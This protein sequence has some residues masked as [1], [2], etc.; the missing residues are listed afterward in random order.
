MAVSMI[1]PVALVLEQVAAPVAV[2]APWKARVQQVDSVSVRSAGRERLKAGRVERFAPG[3]VAWPA[4]QEAAVDLT[5]RARGER[6]RAGAT[7]VSLGRPGQGRKAPGQAR[8]RIVEREV[9]EQLVGPGIVTVVSAEPGTTTEVQLDYSSFAAAAGAGFGSRLSLVAL[10]ACALTTPELAECQ[11]QTDLGSVNDT[12]A[13]T[14]T[15]TVD[16]PATATE[17]PAGTPSPDPSA[18]PTEPATPSASPTAE[19]TPSSSPTPAPAGSQSPAARENLPGE[20]TPAAEPLAL[21]AVV[22]AAAAT[23]SS[24]QGDYTQTSLK[25][26]SSWT[27]GGSS[28]EFTW[29]YPL[30]VPSVPGGL[31]PELGIVYSSGGTDG[32]VSNTNNQASWV[33][34]GFELAGSFIERK[35]ANCYDDRSGGTNKTSN[36]VDLCWDTDSVKTNNEKWDNAFL[37]MD[38]HS[39]ELVREANTANW[40]LEKDDGTRIAK[41]GTAAANN[42]YWRVTT[43][44]GTQYF[45]GKGKA[46][47]SGAAATNSVWKVP[48]SGN[49]SG[50]PGYNSSFG[51]SFVSRPWRW[52]L[53]YVVSPTGN[54]A[55]YYW[56]KEAN[57]YKKNLATSTT[58]D[59]GG[60]LTKIQYGERKAAETVDDSPAKVTFTVEERCDTTVSSTCLTAAPTSSTAK[61]WPDVPMDAYCQTDYCPSQKTS[62]TFFSRKRL[63]Q[64]DTF[65]RNSAGDSW[66]TVDSWTLSGS[67]PAPADGGAVPSLWLASITHTGKAGTTITQPAVTL[68]PMMLDSRIAGSG[69]ALEKPRLALITAETGAQTIVEYS[70]PDCTAATLP[71]E[72]QAPTNTTR[73][74]PVYYSAG[75]AAPTLQWFNKYVVTSVTERDLTGYSDVNLEPLGLDISA[76]QVTSYTYVDGGAWRYNDSPLL[77]KKYRTWSNWRGYGKVVTVTGSGDTRGVVEDTFFRGMNGDR[78]SA[79]GGTRTAEVTDSTGTTWPDEDWFTGMTRET[80]TLTTVNGPEDTG[81]ITDP[82]ASAAISDGRLSSRQIGV[83]KTLRRQQLATGGTRTSIDTT[84]EWDSY[85]QPTKS[86]SE[87]DTAVTGDETC[88]RTSYATPTD[89][90]LGPIDRVAETSSMPTL[91]ATVLDLNQ[92][93]AASRHYYDTSALGSLTATGLETKVEQLTGSGTDRSWTAVARTSYDQWGRATTVTDA[94]DNQTTTT[95][96]HTTGGLV[97]TTTTTTPDPDGAGSGTPLTT[98]KTYDTRLGGPTKTVEPGGQTTEADRDALGRVIAVWSPGRDKATQT[99]TATYSYTVSNTAP[100][101]VTTKTLLPNGTSYQTSVALLDSFLRTRQTQ[102]QSAAGGRLITDTRYDSRGNAVLVDSYYNATAPNTTLVQPNTRGDIPS[103][104]RYRFDFAGRQT[105]DALYSAETQKWETLTT[106]GGDRTHTTPPAGGT[107]TTVI[108]DVFNR[109]TELVHHLGNDTTAPG[110]STHYTY[111]PAGNLASMTDAKNNTWTYTWDLAGNR[112]TAD[113]PD[114]GLTT[115]TYNTLNQLTSTTDARGVTLKYFY[116][117]LGRPTK[118]T[119]A[120]GTTELITTTY[121]TVKKGLVASTNRHLDGGTITNRVEAYDTAGRVTSAATVVPE[122]TGLI[123]AQLAGTYTT[124]STYN[125]DG[126]L[127]T[128][129]LPAA[130]P[131]PAETLTYGYTGLTGLPDTL[132]GTLGATTATYVTDTQYLQ[133]GTVAA[134][135]LGTHTGK[136]IMATY[137]RDQATLRLTGTMLNRQVNPGV[138]DEATT[139]TYDPAGNVTQVTSALAG[140]QLDNQCFTYDHQQQLTEAWTPTTTD[141]DPAGRS[142]AALTGPAPY[143]S[144]WDTDTTGKTTSR[145]DRTTTTSTT[146]TYTYPGDGTDS[147]TPHFIT[148]TTATGTNPG[149]ATYTADQ[150]GNTTSRPGPAGQ[151][152]TL[153]WDDTNQPTEVKQGT[154]TVARMVYDATGARILRQEANT[155]TLYL[156]GAEITLTDSGTQPPLQGTTPTISALRYYTHGGKTL[157]VRTGASNDTVTTLIPDW[158]G[159]THHQVANA[160][161]NLKTTW[162]DPYGNTRGTPPTGWTGE[163]SFVGGTKDATGLIRI[164]ARDYDTVLQRF[165]TVDPIQALAD[166]LQWNPY[167]YANNTPITKAD[168]TGEWT[169]C[170]D[171]CNSKAD[172]AA[173][174]T[175]WQRARISRPSP[176]ATHRAGERAGYG[177]SAPRASST[178]GTMPL[179]PDRAL[180]IA[181]NIDP[182]GNY[183]WGPGQLRPYTY[184]KSDQQR[185]EEQIAADLLGI[186]DAVGCSRGEAGAC[187]A[188]AA[189]FL[190]LGLGKIGKIAKTLARAGEAI[191]AAN[192]LSRLGQGWRATSFGDE[193][194]SFEYHFSKHGAEAGVTREEYAADA[195]DWA[196]KPSGVGK[197]IELKDGSQGISYRTPGGGPGGILDSDGNIITFWYR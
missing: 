160:T 152:Q 144:S 108:T 57:K 72:A 110:V 10:P 52:N 158:Q 169:M 55:T 147:V 13:K 31:A 167:L 1:L 195:L 12:T 69:V 150:A 116:D 20:V 14:L 156:A 3:E 48:V 164:G 178:G 51:S 62:P 66:E 106:Y 26:S 126:S 17:E 98:T 138:T 27:A 118:T 49:H 22:L 90:T 102:T 43:P 29:S 117:A 23:T 100:S 25:G 171:T 123:G 75:T 155:T 187:G 159:T 86:E 188:L 181:Q 84:L 74:M 197:P 61:A 30:R 183:G 170:I 182:S 134:I 193:A 111:D 161:G 89:T 180:E 8:V 19:A 148:G 59:R 6:A 88:T 82:R 133:W 73:C 58:Y 136:A 15:A 81:T 113:D 54:T 42:E 56:A 124:T 128:Q 129:T 130:G 109:T 85:G 44:D 196:S 63:K 163:R 165:V 46:D 143:W 99:A 71:T 151:Q 176:L 68:T 184:A 87:G 132:T 137:T 175:M 105:H 103:S 140:G 67:F 174:V 60:Y 2:A 191:E 4:A 177:R 122:I 36:A 112:L 168:P 179:P 7:P 120:D 146:T 104:H 194:A 70:L 83:A 115:S 21:A 186:T 190:P 91:C 172:R 95:Y 101:T 11:T 80:R 24:E 77:R 114:K 139:L 154:D 145:T 35:Y 65:T 5:G 107:P 34:E 32:G 153:V 189:G 166:P 162:Q 185:L 93:T 18:T 157:A 53:D 38:G 127:K 47:A 79:T 149:S 28:G 40:R 192:D 173:R 64:V 121:D 125:P 92:V 96:T 94:A 135:L 39:G 50:E 119:K 33:G 97:T 78:A 16:L 45:F 9:S 142:Q 41:I 37:S 131:V 76:D 141:C